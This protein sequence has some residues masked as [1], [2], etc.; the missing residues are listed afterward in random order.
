MLMR[1]ALFIRMVFIPG[2]EREFPVIRIEAALF[3]RKN[4]YAQVDAHNKCVE[5]KDEASAINIH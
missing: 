4:E 1:V 2:E 5:L 3:Y